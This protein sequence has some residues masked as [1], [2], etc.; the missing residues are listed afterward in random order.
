VTLVPLWAIAGAFFAL[1]SVTFV[2]LGQA[3]GRA[4][5]AIPNRV[6]AYTI[7][8]FGSLSGI[9]IFAAMS[10][11]SFRRTFGFCRSCCSCCTCRARGLTCK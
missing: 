5:D 8:V 3:M 6:W 1:I 4:F 7:D 9:A 10:Y 2:G 11:S